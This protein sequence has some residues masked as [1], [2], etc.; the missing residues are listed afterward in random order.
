MNNANRVIK[1]DIRAIAREMTELAPQLN[2]KSIL[3]AGGAGFLG[4]YLVL[5]LQYLND[6]VLSTPCKVM[7][8]DNFITGLKGTVEPDENVQL[9]QHDITKPF[10]TDQPID[11]IM[12]AA[13]IASPIFYHK[14][15]LETIDVGFIGTRNLLELAR[16]KEVKSFLFFSS[17]EVYGNPDPKFIPTKEDYF[18]NVS[19]IGPRACYDE[20]KRV[21]ETLCI[22]YA[23][24]YNLPVKIVRP[25]NVFGPG[26]RL[27]DGR[28][29]PNFVVAA[30]RGEKMPL[31]GSGENTRTFCYITDAAVGFFQLLLCSHN[32]EAFNIGADTQEIAMKHLGEMI[33]GLVENETSELSH[34][35][36]PM[37]VYTTA[38]PNRRC[39]D[40]TKIRT[41]VGYKPRITLING[42][43][44]FIAW[45]KEELESE[46]LSYKIEKV[47]RICGNENLRKI[48]SLGKTPLAN[49]LV[50]K[51]D[52]D[53]EEKFPLEVFYCSE[54]HLCQL[55]Y[56]TSPEKMFK[57]Y[58]YVSST[59]ETFKKHFLELSDKI[60]RDLGLNSGSLVV[61]I[62]SNDGI[63]LKNFNE[64]G[65]RTIGVE[66]ADNLIPLARNRGVDTINDFFNERVVEDI[67]RVKGKADVVIANNVFAH[68]HDIKEVVRNI[69]NLLKND[70]V[71]CIEVQYFLD[72]IR[73]S[74]FD[75]IYH[76]HLSYF[77]LLSLNEFFKRQQMEIF[78]VEHIATHGG[79]L[80][81][82]VQKNGGKYPLSTSV[83]ERMAEEHTLGLDKIETYEQ[84][85]ERIYQIR[86]RLQ[87]FVKKLKVEGKKIAGYGAPAKATT[88]LNFCGIDNTQIDYIVE[89][90][91]LKQGLI[92]PGV[93][94]PIVSKDM[95]NTSP[96][97]Y[98][99]ILAWN[100]AQEILQN[101]KEYQERGTKF[102][103]PIP[104]PTLI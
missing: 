60:I 98:L 70:G 49:N 42:I 93:K 4:R 80:R 66:P 6:N 77:T 53:K 19:C 27:D 94:I 68:I 102:F 51:G 55:S 44:R 99:A 36:G 3:I 18:G 14:F 54:C 71:F 12:H 40:L 79:S 46:G 91:P 75:N 45:A 30:L 10:K 9:I 76:E 92:I 83:T 67:L 8:L 31:Y 86:D 81:V 74:T 47:C 59:T 50:T 69:K 57:H 11:Y 35:I 65:M 23:D 17:S 56:V 28:V 73:H 90:N 16:E 101:N 21:G 63:L 48:I 61:E 85:A 34:T 20:P 37:E 33:H 95:L 52:V 103:V 7:V 13:S 43:K 84:F 62:G 89:D 2:G 96:P 22:T 58:V 87:L 100:F 41:M 82:F 24:I 5:T 72:S 32:R 15:R 29:I 39:P 25:F 1:E 88:L 26:M 97:D 38:D 64:K 78:N 104:H